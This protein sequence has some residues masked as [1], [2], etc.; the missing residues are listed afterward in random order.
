VSG[1]LP[2][3]PIAEATRHWCDRGWTNAAPGMAAVTSI[4]RAQQI[5]QARVDAQLKPLGVTFAR[6]EVLMLLT[7][8]RT[9]QLP[10]KV[11]GDRLQVHPTSVTN[12]VDR[13]EADGL[14]RRAPH[15]GDRRALIVALTDSGRETAATATERLNEHV[16]SDVGLSPTDLTALTDNVRHLRS[17]AGDF[18]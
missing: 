15:P 14:V 2:F 17:A 11:I 4:M 16:F 3:D 6:Y 8:S 9:G 18:V 5:V 7:F 10:M 1:P 13:L 12:A